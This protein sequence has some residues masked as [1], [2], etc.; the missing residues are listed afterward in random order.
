M[1]RT[2]IRK[3]SCGFS[4]LETLV[5]VSLIMIVSTVAVIQM[6]QSLATLDADRA[7]DLVVSEIRYAR[8]IA[9]D[10]RRDTLLEFISPNRI[11]VTRQDGGGAT[12]VMADV[13]LPSGY[14]FG[15]PGGMSDTPDGYGNS[16][17]VYFNGGTSGTFLGDGIFVSGA[18]VLMNG[19]VFT[20][21]SG[22][23]SSR[24]VT[25]SGSSGRT[26]SYY[27]QGTTWVER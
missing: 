3:R 9:V 1:T 11:T 6:R 22:N 19:S 27:I 12:T 14:S 24:A 5:V 13:T 16:A 4:L 23:G 7:A 15:L 20:I 2:H 18:G 25:L 8:Q 21:G 26:K 10:Q 17:A